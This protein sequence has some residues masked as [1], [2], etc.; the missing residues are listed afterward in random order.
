MDL[1][2]AG[3]AGIIASRTPDAPFASVVTP[4]A[5]HL[6]RLSRTPS[7][8]PLYEGAWMLLLDSRVV[9]RLA[10][11]LGLAAPDVATGADL[12]EILIAQHVRPGDRITVIGLAAQH[13]PQLQARMPGAIIA[14]LD[15][16][17]G[18]DSNPA[19]FAQAVDFAITHPARFTFL[20]IGS[21]RQERLAAAIA[22]AGG[23][24]VGL[25]IGAALEFATG[26][27]ARAPGW[28]QRAGL[29]WLHRL[30]KDPRRLAKRYLRDDPAILLLL[31]KARLRR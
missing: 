16:P 15:P 18:M 11:M 17:H 2:A 9:R 30:A 25:C 1:D 23:T 5:D 21:P 27:V 4:N 19:A 31:L 6:V 12:A 28:V 10:G 26:A 13:L 29:E 20:A 22:A 3:A 7:L 8:L 14:H 24:G